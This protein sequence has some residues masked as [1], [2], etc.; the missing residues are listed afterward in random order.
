MRCVAVMC[1][2]AAACGGDSTTGT[3][4]TI[5]TIPADTTT[6]QTTTTTD[7]AATTEPSTTTAPTTTMPGSYA[8][9]YQGYCV[10]GTD[11]SDRLNVRTAPGGEHDIIGSL[12]FN[13]TG[14]EATGVAAPD[15]RGRA[16][17]EIVFEGRTGWSAGWYLIP[18]PC[19]SAS[20]SPTPLSAPGFLDALS[21]GLV[22]WD[23]V[24]DQ[25]I[26]F[27]Y[28]PGSGQ[29]YAL[30]LLSP[31]GDLYEVY[32]WD[33]S[34]ITSFFLL[35][36]RPDGRA[37]LV[38]ADLV[39]TTGADLLMFDLPGR[40][41]ATVHTA[42]F[43][44]AFR[45]SFTR[46]TG[47]DIVLD[48]NDPARER[49]EVRRTS[50]SLFSVLVDRP[51][52]GWDEPKTTWLYGLGGVTV[53]TGDDDGLRLLDNQGS[54]IR[55]LDSP[56]TNCKPV[57]WWN[58]STVVAGCVPDDVIAL[59]PMSIYQQLWR[60]PTDGSA[61]T[62]ITDPPGYTPMEVDFGYVD[63]VRV[64]GEVYVQ[65][66][67]DCG[68]GG[69]S[70]V[71]ARGASVVVFQWTPCWDAPFSIDLVSLDGSMIRSLVSDG[72]IE[73]IMIRDAP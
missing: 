13:A 18:E 33:A 64:G 36:W 27:N 37:L 68:A 14:V 11:P 58:A 65:W 9:D 1:L 54:L 8:V 62:A 40:S 48:V 5:A 45:A 66:A 44:S 23:W 4:S 19:G 46:P 63:M 52:P 6:L 47:R 51:L 3:S 7:G 73:A 21:G 26:L 57:H 15:G 28:W 61:A 35:D 30:Y 42:P 22:P 39:G 70:L 41:Y 60:V 16:W 50:G 67:G 31:Q 32:E 25:W 12:A 69:R 24:D 59:V 20:A 29:A 53:V 38:G 2:I 56:G 43:P 55:K 10:R 49:I 34:E 71:G 17:F 72:V